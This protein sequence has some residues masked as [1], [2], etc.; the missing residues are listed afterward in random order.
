MLSRPNHLRKVETPCVDVPVLL[1]ERRDSDSRTEEDGEETAQ[2]AG[3]DT[4]GINA[5]L[6]PFIEMSE[7]VASLIQKVAE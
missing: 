1:L 3:I 2:G 4:E 6:S 7:S 5:E